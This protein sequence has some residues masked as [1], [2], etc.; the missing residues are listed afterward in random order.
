MKTVLIVDDDPT[1]RGV[2]KNMLQAL[3]VI[4]LEA[5]DGRAAVATPSQA[6]IDLAV[7]DMF[8]PG[9]GGL[10][11]IQELR[12]AQPDMRFIA[13]SGGQGFDPGDVLP[14]SR[15]LDITDTLA[16]PLDRKTVLDTVGRLLKEPPQG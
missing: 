8:L 3:P 7:V 2:L 12:Q 6:R 5:G 14:L 16:K 1:T 4:C 13:M 10:D 15:L 11:V 9:K